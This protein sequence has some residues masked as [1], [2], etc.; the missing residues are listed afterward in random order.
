LANRN[1][2]KVSAATRNDNDGFSMFPNRGN[3]S[4]I[5]GNKGLDH[6]YARERGGVGMRK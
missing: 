4:H 6:S 3:I 5:Q 2:G 1:A